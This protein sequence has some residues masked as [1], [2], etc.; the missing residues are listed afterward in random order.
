M[1][2]KRKTMQHCAFAG[3][4]ARSQDRE[5]KSLVVDEF[6]RNGAATSQSGN[7]EEERCAFESKPEHNTVSYTTILPAYVH[8]RH[9][10]A[11]ARIFALMPRCGISSW[12][13]M[14]TAFFHALNLSKA[15]ELFSQMPERDL[16]SWTSLLWAY[17][18]TGTWTF[19]SMPQPNLISHAYRAPKFWNSWELSH[20]LLCARSGEVERARSCFVSMVM[21]YELEAGMENYSC[22]VDALSRVGCLDQARDWIASMPFTSMDNLSPEKF[23]SSRP[24]YI[25]ETMAQW[26][27]GIKES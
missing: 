10:E 24:L 4:G 26:H 17:A 14:L 27:V 22:K 20:L 12:N 3:R 1:T 8:N 5:V 16:A 6:P 25:L 9:L 23:L 19:D 2:S 11:A 18:Q 15:E 21:N 7:L 13:A